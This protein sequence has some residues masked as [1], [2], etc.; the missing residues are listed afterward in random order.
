M[1]A[2]D[3]EGHFEEVM[4]VGGKQNTGKER[5]AGRCLCQAPHTLQK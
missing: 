4:V 2:V 5:Q 1:R 3:R